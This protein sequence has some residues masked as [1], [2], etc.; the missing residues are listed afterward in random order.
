MESVYRSYYTKSDPLVSYMIS[1][2]DLQPGCTVAEPCAGDGVFVDAVLC[3]MP[4]AKIDAYE[5]NPEAVSNLR[6]KYSGNP[7]V[8]V[9]HADTLTDSECSI[10]GNLGVGYDRIVGNPPYGGWQDYDKRDF[11]K[12]LYPGLYVK[13]TY[14]LFLHRCVR[15]LKQSGKL[16]FILPDTFL[17]LHMHTPLRQFLL[18]HCTVSEVAIFPSQFF[19]ASGMVTP[20]CA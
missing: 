17:N 15:L 5:L 8:S 10:K 14:A 3:E 18:T 11:L 7:S 9:L 12:K 4:D 2:L 13:E 20:K 6:N 16:V 1:Q 19:P